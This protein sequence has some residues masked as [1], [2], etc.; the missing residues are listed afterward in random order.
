MCKKVVRNQHH[1]SNSRFLIITGRQTS[2]IMQDYNLQFISS[3][4]Q[5][6]HP[7]FEEKDKGGGGA[8]PAWSF[9]CG[10]PAS[11]SALGCQIPRYTSHTD[12]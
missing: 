10:T 4:L 12:T 11:E 5:L 9:M 2:K 8:H 1:K 3:P 6:F 7:F